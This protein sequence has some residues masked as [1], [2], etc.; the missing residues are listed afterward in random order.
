MK[1]TLLATTTCLN[2]RALGNDVT[3]LP[4]IAIANERLLR[5]PQ[6][7]EIIPIGKS[8]FWK[9]VAEGRA[10]KGIKLAARTTCW[11]LSEIQQFVA[12]LAERRG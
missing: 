12:E 2:T 3:P 4:P 1:K 10:P 5:L 7:L 6:V 11:R 9:M 8:S